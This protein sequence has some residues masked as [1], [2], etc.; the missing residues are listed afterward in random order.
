MTCQKKKT[1][2]VYLAPAALCACEARGPAGNFAVVK[3]TSA[4]L[5]KSV[6]TAMRVGNVTREP[7]TEHLPVMRRW[8]AL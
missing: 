3:V 7:E 8:M 1:D 5:K 2:S 6:Y 4:F